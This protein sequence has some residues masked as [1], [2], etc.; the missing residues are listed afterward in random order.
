MNTWC[1]GVGTALVL[2]LSLLGACVGDETED[3]G[4]DED[5]E[6][7]GCVFES[8]LLDS[9]NNPE[10]SPWAESCVDVL[11]EEDCTLATEE[12]NEQVG[13]CTFTTTYR[14]VQTTPGLACPEMDN[15]ESGGPEEI[16]PAELGEACIN[17]ADCN[18]GLCVPRFYCTT[19]CA[20]S[21]ECADDF[22]GGCCIGEGS[23]GYC[24]AAE[25]CG[26]LCP[27]NST[28]MG[29]P[30]ICVCDEGFDYDV[31]TNACVAM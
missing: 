21:T 4:P 12:M 14:N 5:A 30:T 10:G 11:T 17:L 2:A 8:R 29:L 31:E 20:E 23:L 22:P 6:R 3:E 15:A 9:C 7:F 1:G 24:L 27:E 13:E 18:S 19:S 28:A 25:D 16:E 26:G